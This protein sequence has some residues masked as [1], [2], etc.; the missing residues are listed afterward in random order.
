MQTFRM[1][2][3]PCLLRSDKTLPWLR[4]VYIIR[5]VFSAGGVVSQS[6]SI[7]LWCHE[8]A[9]NGGLRVE[10]VDLSNEQ[11]T[12]RMDVCASS[13]EWRYRGGKW[14]GIPDQK[15]IIRGYRFGDRG[16]DEVAIVGLCRAHIV[17][18]NNEADS[19][20]SQQGVQGRGTGAHAS[21]HLPGVPEHCIG[22]LHEPS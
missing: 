20:D 8:G 9:R 1:N 10:G 3:V 14:E 7:A 16:P 18:Y 6:K 21:N 4:Y 15:E 13:N 22:L 11:K 2:K 19:V 12:K 5:V 17:G